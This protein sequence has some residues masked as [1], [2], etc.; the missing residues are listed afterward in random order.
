MATYSDFTQQLGKAL[1]ISEKDAKATADTFI[2]TVHQFIKHGESVSLQGLGKFEIK[3][4]K[5]GMA[6]GF[7]PHAKL[8]KC[9]KYTAAY[10]NFQK[11]ADDLGLPKTKQP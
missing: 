3:H 10:E 5:K 6:F 7:A 2:Q 9:L 11:A 1:K 4:N 8:E